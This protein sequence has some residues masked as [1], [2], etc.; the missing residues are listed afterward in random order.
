MITEA[1]H[2]IVYSTDSLHKM[3]PTKRTLIESMVMSLSA[4]SF[5]VPGRL[6]VSKKGTDGS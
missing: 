2:D 4:T 3:P 5:K 6:V 1:C